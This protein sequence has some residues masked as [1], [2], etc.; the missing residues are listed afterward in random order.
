MSVRAINVPRGGFPVH[1]AYRARDADNP[2]I[3]A[4]LEAAKEK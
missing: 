2:L 1:V 3:V 4:A